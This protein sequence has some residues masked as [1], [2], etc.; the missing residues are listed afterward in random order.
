MATF[1]GGRYLDEQLGSILSNLSDS[2]E[3][4]VSD[5][6]SVD[7]TMD[8]LKRC[9]STNPGIRILNGPR[10]GVIRNFE[11]AISNA[12]GDIIFL[13]DQDDVWKPGKAKKVAALF[14]DEMCQAVV[15]NA[16]IVDA[17]GRPTGKS[18]FELRKSG[19][20]I[21]KNLVRNSFVGCCMAFRSNLRS[22]IL[23]FPEGIEMHDWWIGLVAEAYGGTQFLDIPLI[24]YR[25]HDS[26]ASAMHHH[27]LPKMVHN[28]A[29]LAYELV[30]R[31]GRGKL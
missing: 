27:P 29:K 10:A 3:I 5:D 6:G 19:S 17:R 11:H 8:I 24:E 9:A 7:N 28:R 13:S 12:S 21:V 31:K 30:R 2:D 1:N 22:N 15:H 20:G 14:D 26:N 4:I 25:R 16:E 18:L 23:P